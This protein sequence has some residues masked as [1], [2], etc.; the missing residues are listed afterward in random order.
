MNE[1]WAIQPNTTVESTTDESLSTTAQ[2]IIGIFIGAILLLILA[3]AA[4][5]FYLWWKNK[6]GKNKISVTSGADQTTKDDGDPE[7]SHRG[8]KKK[9]KKKSKKD[10]WMPA[11]TEN[12][13][14]QVQTGT[15]LQPIEI[16]SQQIT[17]SLAIVN[18]NRFVLQNDGDKHNTSGV[19]GTK[20]KKKGR[21]VR[22]E[23][24]GKVMK[25][26]GTSNVNKNKLEPLSNKNVTNSGVT[27]KNIEVSQLN[28]SSQQNN[29]SQQN[30]MATS[31]S[32]SSMPNIQYNSH[33]QP[34]SS[35]N[36]ISPFASLVGMS[37]V[38]LLSKQQLQNKA[39]TMQKQS[40]NYTSNANNYNSTTNINTRNN[41]LRNSFN[42]TDTNDNQQFEIQ[43]PNN[44]FSGMLSR[45]NR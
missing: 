15:T 13:E 26:G 12:N 9:D 29:Y 10:K 37:P 34:S 2:I 7:S 23:P 5:V 21:V 1:S 25:I 19:S 6:H 41:Q 16:K 27:G 24:V 3:G 14:N 39:Q 4:Y 32:V 36:Q 11:T 45:M 28:N 22:P 33:L 18:K 35:T 8:L 40:S 20:G 38:Q 42:K 30:L 44:M 17:T 31:A 43:D